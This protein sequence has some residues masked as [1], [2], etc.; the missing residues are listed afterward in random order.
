MAGDTVWLQE[1]LERVALERPLVERREVEEALWRHLSAIGAETDSFTWVEDIEQGF[2]RVRSELRSGDR[3][4]SPSS[5]GSWRRFSLWSP[6]ARISCPDRVLPRREDPVGTPIARVA[7]SSLGRGWQVY[8][9]SRTHHRWRES[10]AHVDDPVSVYRLALAAAD[11]EAIVMAGRPERGWFE[12]PDD[13]FWASVRGDALYEQGVRT[14]E[15]ARMRAPVLEPLVAAF[16]A[17]LGFFWMGESKRWRQ[18][19]CLAVPRPALHLENGRLHRRDG[20]AVE[21]PNGTS[22]WFWEGLNI[23]R[24]VAAKDSERARLQ[25]LART[26]NL[27]KRRL[28]LERIGYERFLEIT[29]AELRQQD[30]YGK[31][32]TTQLAFDD[33]QLM[34]VEVAN[35]TPE[36]DGTRRRYF[37][38]VPP[39][40]QTAR[41]AVAWS[42]GYDDETE[43][44]PGLET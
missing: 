9:T 25:V 42:F 6:D 1:R 2:G 34:V 8:K 23:P 16:E 13:D 31:L 22:Y 10:Y 3:V 33:E 43:Y 7:R 38:R 37:L 4:W 14:Y 40:T 20:P 11:E 5:S 41:A 39:D 44:A 29:G 21:W 18:R 35:A 19:W 15:S 36:P 26:S 27:E 32:W 17:G 24:R 12:E 28:L 30:D